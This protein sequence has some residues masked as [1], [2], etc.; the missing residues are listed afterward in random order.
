MTDPTE[1]RT[2]CRFCIAFCG[3]MVSVADDGSDDERP[4]HG[5]RVVAVRGDTDHPTSRGYLCPKGRALGI[6]HH[7]P[8]RLD[9]PL[10]GRGAEQRPVA[11]GDLLDDAAS[12]LQEIIAEHGPSSVAFFVGNGG[13]FDATGR[14]ALERLQQ[15]VGSKVRF[16]NMTVDTPAKPVIGSLMAHSPILVPAV[17]HE[18]AS[19]VVLIGCN[20]VV[21]HGH[22]NSFPDPV[23]RLRETAERGELW[24]IDPRRSESAELATH[25]LAIRPDTD[26]AFL[27]HVVREILVEG[28]DRAYLAE[29]AIQLDELTTA[30]EPFTLDRAVRLTGLEP[31][32]IEAFVAAVR[33][34]GRIAM[35]TGTGSTFSTRATVIEWLVWALSIITGSYDRPGGMWFQPGFFKQLDQRDLPKVQSPYVFGPA[36]ASR[37]DLRNITGETPAAAFADEVAAGTIRAAVIAGLNPLTSYPDLARQRK[38]LDGLEVLVVADVMAS[39]LTDAAT[40]VM[41][42]SAPLE[43]ADLSYWADFLMINVSGQHTARVVEP[44]AERRPQWQA[45]A[46]LGAGMGLDVIGGG[47]DPD[48]ITE[49]EIIDRVGRGARRPIDE[50]RAAPTAVVA[51]ES[52]FGWVHDRILPDDGWRLAP[53]ALCQSLAALA[54]QSPP[55]LAPDAGQ[56]SLISARQHRHVNFQLTGVPLGG[57]HQDEPT[58]VMHPADAERSGVADGGG[59]RVTSATGELATTVELSDRMLPGAVALSQGFE[60]TNVCALVGDGDIDPHSGMVRQTA[61]PVTVTPV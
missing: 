10:L 33:H 61:F 59:V 4:G 60:A 9:H 31:A 34:H 56:L 41:P 8:R 42:V 58:L 55:D 36:P 38:A 16:T 43:R 19:L 45:L 15:R 24:V 44:A 20:P 54:R 32:S 12:R 17:D 22:M 27:A 48:T 53:P 30:V 28:A 46:Q 7:D 23:R 11:W 2:F 26:W 37:P 50:L 14:W 29:H 1:H 57:G 49:E 47:A 51:D 40:H 3:A 6:N 52:V 18:R 5:A 39:E 25:H 13:S 21:S 35:Q